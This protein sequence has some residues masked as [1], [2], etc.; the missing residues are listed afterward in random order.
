MSRGFDHLS[1]FGGSSRLPKLLEFAHR[2]LLAS[3]L[4]RNVR[5]VDLECLLV[6]NKQVSPVLLFRRLC[7]GLL[8]ADQKT[9]LEVEES[10]EIEEDV[11]HLVTADYALLFNKLLELLQQLE[12]LDV[13]ALRLDELVD[14]VLALCAL[15]RR[16]KGAV[17]GLRCADLA[18]R[19]ERVQYAIDYV[20]D[21]Y[22]R[23][24]ACIDRTCWNGPH[25]HESSRV[26]AIEVA[27][28]EAA[29]LW[30]A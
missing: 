22:A 30:N 2:Y 13:G 16:G 17:R 6:E 9:T 8:H 5:L 4:V 1:H 18:E 24:A 26:V 20:G 19:N 3:F 7:I 12:M 28:D 11:V 15:D 21:L 25:L 29:F 10:I 27:Q 23:L 14:D